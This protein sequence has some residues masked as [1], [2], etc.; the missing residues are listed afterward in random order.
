MITKEEE[1]YILSRA[2]VPEHIPKMMS[3][4]SGGEPFL[5]DNKYV[6][7]QGHNFII[8]IGYSLD[9]L[10]DSAEIGKY[11]NMVIKNFKNSN[12]YILTDGNVSKFF[13]KC[14]KIDD[15]FYY[16]L[17]V[18]KISLE[19]RL[20]RIV[21]KTQKK[22]SIK[23]EKE[24]TD[25]HKK[26]TEEFLRSKNLPMQII[27][28]YRRLPQYMNF[29]DKIF[30]LSAYSEDGMLTGYYIVETEAKNFSAYMIGCISKL[31]YVPYT[32]DCLMFEL[33]KISQQMG[34]KYINLGIGVNDGIRR[35]KEKWGAV[36]Y[37]KYNV[38]ECQTVFSFFRGG[39]NYD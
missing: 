10:N 29:S 28:L 19:K 14:N 36:K 32:S 8:F 16:V 7:F 9:S 1:S 37:L 2:Y 15:D 11:L 38:Y 26:L 6:I 27:E 17:D 12:L 30:Y 4:L 22:L 33:I 20:L 35:F 39:L 3:F 21:E 31:H 34:K 18:E 23:I 24:T 5:I 25:K 13:K